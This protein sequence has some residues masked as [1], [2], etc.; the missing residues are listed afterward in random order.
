[1][2]QDPITNALGEWAQNGTASLILRLVLAML[3]GGIVGWERSSKRHAAGLRTFM[4]TCVA[5]CAAVLLD[6]HIG[7]SMSFTAAACIIA[8]AIVSVNCVLFS[9]NNRIKGLTTCAALFMQGI[10]GMLIGAGLLTC[11]LACFIALL[12][13]LYLFPPLETYLKDHSNHFELNVEFNNPKNMGEF[14]ETL[15]RL[16]LSVD[17]VEVDT[18]YAGTGLS[19]YRFEVTV[20]S[21]ALKKYR[22]H[23]E[24]VDAL[25]SLEY[26]NH[27]EEAE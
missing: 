18:A 25:R 24:I 8:F 7:A 20:R 11:A 10:V 13:S 15:R 2:I 9:N 21:E 26:L 6:T 1:M 16:G 19:V 14:T 27:I 4:L 12:I 3:A 23:R 5:G 17:E 22:T